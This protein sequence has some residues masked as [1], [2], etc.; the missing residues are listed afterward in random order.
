MVY[1]TPTVGW[2]ADGRFAYTVVDS[3]LTAFDRDDR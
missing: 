2:S 3:T 1:S